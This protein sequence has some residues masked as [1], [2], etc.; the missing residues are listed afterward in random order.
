[1]YWIGINA[2]I[3]DHH[4]HESLWRDLPHG[5]LYVSHFV[6]MDGQSVLR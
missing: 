4:V 6:V 3:V 5:R 2:V 1:M